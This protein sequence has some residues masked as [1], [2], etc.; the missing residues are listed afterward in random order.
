MNSSTNNYKKIT[1]RQKKL[2]LNVAETNS[3]SYDV[4]CLCKIYQK[5]NF[6]FIFRAYIPKLTS[7]KQLNYLPTVQDQDSSHPF[8]SYLVNNFLNLLCHEFVL[9]TTHL[10]A[11]CFFLKNNFSSLRC[12]ICGM[13]SLL[14]I[15]CSTSLE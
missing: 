4:L 9:S 1:Q 14:S 7:Y 15:S 2:I 5:Y 6:Q 10:L 8:F 3:N 12:L 13:Y 11:G